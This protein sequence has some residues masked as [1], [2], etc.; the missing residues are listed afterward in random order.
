M[1]TEYDVIERTLRLLGPVMH[2][3]PENDVAL[4]RWLIDTFG[5]EDAKA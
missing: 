1:L 5:E 3:P 2:A 4:A